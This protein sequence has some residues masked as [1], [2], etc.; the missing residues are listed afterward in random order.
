MT[1]FEAKIEVQQK[2]PEGKEKLT[3]SEQRFQSLEERPDKLESALSENSLEDSEVRDFDPNFA[4]NMR[5][6]IFSTFEIFRSE[7]D[8][9]L[10]GMVEGMEEMRAHIRVLNCALANGG[11]SAGTESK[12]VKAR[13]PKPF[14]VS[15]YLDDDANLWWRRRADDLEASTRKVETWED[16]KK[17]LKNQLFPEDVDFQARKELRAL[18][19]M[20]TFR[21]YVRFFSS[22]MLSIPKMADEDKLFAFLDGLRPWA[23]NEL[24]RREVKTLT[25][26]ISTAEKLTKFERKNRDVALKTN[27]S[28]AKNQ[29][30]YEKKK[31]EKGKTSTREEKDPKNGEKKKN[32]QENGKSKKLRCFIC[33]EEHYAR[34]CPKKKLLNSLKGEGETSYGDEE[35]RMSSMA[36]LNVVQTSGRKITSQPVRPKQHLLFLDL[37]LNGIKVKALV[38]TG[39]TH[40]FISKEEPRR[41]GLSWEKDGSRMK[42]VNST[43]KEACGIAK[44]VCITLGKW[45][46]VLDFT[47]V[48]MDDFNVI[49][50]MDSLN[51]SL[52]LKRGLN[53]GDFTYLATLLEEKPEGLVVPK[54][55][56]R[57]LEEYKY[58]MPK[59]LPHHLPPRREV[60]HKI[61]LEPGT[62]PLA[63]APYWMA[64][65][66]LE[67][68]RRQ[69]GEML[70]TGFIQPSKAPYGGPVLFQKKKDNSMR[71]CRL[72][73]S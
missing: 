47:I 68:L 63:K 4:K 6:D 66:E 58:V 41:L 20:G 53:Q 39:D 3:K 8:E 9:K 26:A 1:T 42:A 7:M 73:S 30:P 17:E 34:D 37:L 59:E 35:Q 54:E 36:L 55:I 14:T 57:V 44:S 62:R 71:L 5:D 46:G 72:S 50:G 15:T 18:K 16:F 22:L 33:G 65:K 60:D 23:H 67:E 43:A 29:K 12:K 40:K 11:S 61:E 69:L 51:T 21:E 10:N 28:G 25:T 56:T 45:V 2:Q 49:L 24:R 70:D 38:D 48:P 19:Q 27:K 13:E 32:G 31:F 52:Q 64:P